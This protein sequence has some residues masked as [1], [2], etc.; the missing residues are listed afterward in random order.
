MQSNFQHAYVCDLENC[1]LAASQI[2]TAELDSL[3]SDVVED[4]PLAKKAS[5]STSFQS[6]RDTKAAQIDPED[7][8]KTTQIGTALGDK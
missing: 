2:A 6:A 5:A 8:S 1:N 3:K 7:P 4:A